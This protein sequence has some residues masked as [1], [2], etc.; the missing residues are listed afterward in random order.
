MRKGFAP[1][2]V[3]V[4]FT[5]VSVTRTASEESSV[6]VYMQQG[7]PGRLENVARDFL[8]AEKKLAQEAAEGA[9]IMMSCFCGIVSTGARARV[10]VMGLSWQPLG[11]A[12]PV[13]PG[14]SAKALSRSHA[15]TLALHNSNVASRV[16]QGAASS[17]IVLSGVIRRPT[18]S[19]EGKRKL[20]APLEAAARTIARERCA[21]TSLM[22]GARL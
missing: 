9:R 17:H 5:L 1:L 11:H 2:I 14:P 8:E 3:M 15:G 22:S 12:D 7:E 13:H 10:A 16:V 19:E 6:A 4:D 20:L 18:R 21:S